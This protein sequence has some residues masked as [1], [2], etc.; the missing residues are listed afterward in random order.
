MNQTMDSSSSPRLMPKG[1]LVAA[2]F[3]LLA[4]LASTEVQAQP[5]GGWGIYS[6]PQQGFFEIPH[7]AVLNPTGQ[8]TIEGWVA[9]SDPGSCG[10]IIGKGWQTAW[11]VG[12]CNGT[13]RTY[14]RG[15][16][17]Q[18]NGGT[19]TNDWNHF[20]V[21]FDGTH[22]RHYVN[23]ELAAEFAEANPLTTNSQPV[24]IGS[25]VNYNGFSPNGTI[26]E[27]RLWNVAR[28]ITQIRATI[29]R[30]LTAPQAGLVAVWNG[31]GQDQIGPHD[32]VLNGSV[33]GLTFPVTNQACSNTTTSLC[34][35]GR[36]VADIRWRTSNASDTAE[37]APL[38]TNQSGIFWF[39]DEENWEVMVK[40]LN[41]C[42][43]NNRYWIF[44]AATTNVSYRLE[45]FDQR[46]GVQKIYFNYP[47]PPAPAVTDTSA[48]A[49][50]P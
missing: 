14:L 44:S 23:G 46:A 42:A 17:S 48:F 1:F 35:F 11:W 26:N 15:S 20:A 27:L 43:I 10:N 32:G 21:T 24:R 31:F 50:C 29:N 22:R 36:F 6:R 30:S 49:T 33:P 40:A 12:V 45:V 25:D 7:N 9:V 41:G 13:L 47:G 3:V 2:A 5:F 4:T 16:S 18:R 8:I 19:L 34:L 39:F 37:L 38:T 28:T